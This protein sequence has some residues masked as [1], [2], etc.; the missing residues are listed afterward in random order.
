MKGADRFEVG[1]SCDGRLELVGRGR[2][3][4]SVREK[5]RR[6]RRP[7]LGRDDKERE[8]QAHKMG[9][10]GTAGVERLQWTSQGKER[11]NRTF[12]SVAATTPLMQPPF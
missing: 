8:T 9:L 7:V 2:D 12:L 1:D 11:H 3:P 4:N 10:Q 6:K 5:R